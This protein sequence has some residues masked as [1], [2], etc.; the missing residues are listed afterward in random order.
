MYLAAKCTYNSGLGHGGLRRL[1]SFSDVESPVGPGAARCVGIRR[2]T[3]GLAQG[4]AATSDAN[5]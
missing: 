2:D 4:L 5:W 1:A 3:N